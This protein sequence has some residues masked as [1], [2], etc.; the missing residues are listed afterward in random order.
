[1]ALL[2]LQRAMVTE[3]SGLAAVLAHLPLCALSLT[4]KG[5]RAS[6]RAL[7]ERFRC[8]CG[9]SCCLRRYKFTR[10][11]AS[12]SMRSKL[13]TSEFYLGFF[14]CLLPYWIA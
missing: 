10:R 8:Q 13:T 3:T 11:A 14:A 5:K 9:A 12:H 4:A 7:D 6:E 1:M 2:L